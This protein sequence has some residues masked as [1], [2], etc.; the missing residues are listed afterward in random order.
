[1]RTLSDQSFHKGQVNYNSRR[2]EKAFAYMN[3]NYDK[4]INLADIAKLTNMTEV[5]F[6]RFIKSVLERAL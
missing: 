1:M 5:S 4:Q 6:S 3:N 2:I